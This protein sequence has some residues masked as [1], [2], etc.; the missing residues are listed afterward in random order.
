VLK[1]IS[2]LNFRP[3]PMVSTIKLAQSTKSQA[4]FSCFDEPG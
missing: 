3:S 4:S 1:K 2:G